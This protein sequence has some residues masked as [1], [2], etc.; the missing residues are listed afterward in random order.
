[1]LFCFVGLTGVFIH[2]AALAVA[3]GPGRLGFTPA[4]AVAT[5]IAITWNFVVNNRLTYRD[6][7]LIG[8]R[9]LSGL[10]RFQLICAVG[11][12]SNVGAAAS[13]YHYN[14]NWWMAGLGGAL[15]GVV[16]NYAVSAAFVWHQR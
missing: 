6:Q 8:W 13:I 1:L 14:S 5:V 16:W 12:V 11:A 3:L 4:Q 2:M 10:L 15:M 9:F 7:R